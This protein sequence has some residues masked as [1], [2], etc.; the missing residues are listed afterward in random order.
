MFVAKTT[1]G[2]KH[3]NGPVSQPLYNHYEYDRIND[4]VDVRI[5]EI[6]HFAEFLHS[7]DISSRIVADEIVQILKKIP[8]LERAAIFFRHGLDLKWEDAAK[9]L[10]MSRSSTQRLTNSA[11]Q[12]CREILEQQFK[13]QQQQKERE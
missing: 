2:N 10:N 11:L 8:R 4:S 3:K 13:E 12:H 1:E 9:K 6:Q 7:T 5:R